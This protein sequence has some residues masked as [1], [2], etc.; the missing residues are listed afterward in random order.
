[1]GVAALSALKGDGKRDAVF[2]LKIVFFLGW[3]GVFSVV[4][5]KRIICLSTRLGICQVVPA[6]VVLS[7]YYNCNRWK[8][9]WC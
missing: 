3:L 5:A 9:R 4:A 6:I 7:V 2:L 1:M 8:V